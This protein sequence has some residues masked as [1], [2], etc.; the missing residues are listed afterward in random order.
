MLK[1]DLGSTE[2]VDCYIVDTILIRV[3]YLSLSPCL[4]DNRRL[5]WSHIISVSGEVAEWLKAPV[6]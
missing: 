6:C 4:A 1:K 2:I 5:S 3:D